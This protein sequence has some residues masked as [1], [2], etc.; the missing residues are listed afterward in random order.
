MVISSVGLL[1]AWR[2]QR[3]WRVCLVL[4]LVASISVAVAMWRY[5][6][7][8]LGTD[9]GRLLYPAIAPLIALFVIGLL[10]WLPVHQGGK[11]GV[12]LVLGSLLLGI[13]GLLGVIQPNFAPTPQMVADNRQL[14]STESI[15]FDELSIVDWDLQENPTIYWRAQQQPS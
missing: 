14:A 7:M 9:Q 13:Y 10:S 4:L 6:L 11:A 2:N 5:S 12:G 8:A 1:R 15:D 3:E